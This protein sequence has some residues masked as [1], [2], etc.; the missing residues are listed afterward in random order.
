MASHGRLVGGTKHGCAGA[1]GWIEVGDLS[2]IWEVEM[3]ADETD[4]VVSTGDHQERPNQQ[5]SLETSRS[6]SMD[7]L[8]L[9][10]QQGIGKGP[11]ILLGV[12]CAMLFILAGT[13]GGVL[14]A[15]KQAT[16]PDVKEIQAAVLA[17]VQAMPTVKPMP[18]VDAT[19]TTV[20]MAF[21]TE[22]PTRVAATV[23]A[24]LVL[25]PT[26]VAIVNTP[27]QP[28]SIVP[29][30]NLTPQPTIPPAPT[31]LPVQI[32]GRGQRVS[33]PLHL[34]Q[35][36]AIFHLKHLGGDSN[37]IDYATLFL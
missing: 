13:V 29:T 27:T 32:T 18:D 15:P 5:L 31:T 36:L 6:Q 35:G 1:I 26:H 8:P 7:K 34:V 17:T 3:P 12:L 28:A 11:L 23:A 21:E 37:F 19:L 16:S 24:Q 22:I 25:L 14:L 9:K 10:Q 30:P 33:E 20:A 4:E 2:E